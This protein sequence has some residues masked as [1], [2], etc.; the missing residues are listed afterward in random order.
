MTTLTT[1]RIVH[2]LTAGRSLKASSLLNL[3]FVFVPLAL[4]G[5]HLGFGP[6]FIFACAALSCVPLSF[7]L[8]RSTE[9]LGT[10][11]GPIS[12]GLLNATFGN[13]AELIISVFALNQGLFVLVRTSLIGSILGQ[14]LLVLGTSLLVAGLM[15]KE[16]RFSGKLVQINFTLIAITLVAI[17]LPTVFAAAAPDASPPNLSFLTPALAITLILIYSM[18]VFYSL[19]SQPEEVD[20]GGPSWAVAF[21]LFVLAAS[22]GGMI[23]VSELLVSNVVPFIEQTGVSEVFLGLILIPI[24]SNVVD[25]VVAISVAMK[26]RMDLSLTISVGS[27]AQVGALVLP[28]IM[29]V[30]FAMGEPQAMVFTSME[31]VALG[32]GLTLMVPVLLDGLSNWLEGAQLLACYLILASVLWVM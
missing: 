17:G 29:L 31:L 27:A 7:W 26:N 3:M 32:V 1:K 14:L 22:T 12:G 28:V 18:A 23:V 20:N 6:V 4:L 5:E 13:A 8:G 19:R 10:R 15:H 9:A 25:H 16:L 24:F 21:A 30:S 2:T 11:L